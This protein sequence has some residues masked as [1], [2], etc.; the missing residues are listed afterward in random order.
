[1]KNKGFTLPEILVSTVIAILVA[2]CL[3]NLFIVGR[4]S[5]LIGETYLDL[6]QQARMAMDAVAKELSQS[7]SSQVHIMSCP[8]LGLNCSGNIVSFKLPISDT[9]DIA[10]TVFKPDGTIKWGDMG[11][12]GREILF[13]AT[14]SPSN[15]LIRRSVFSS[16]E[17]AEN[18]VAYDIIQI[19]FTGFT[20]EGQPTA[21]NPAMVKI[22]V[23]AQRAAL[24]AGN[25]SL[26][27]T[28][29]VTFR[30]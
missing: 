7:G 22:S 29:S 24:I 13:Y 9:L 2:I 10:N 16:S 23:L 30:N 18:N 4:N 12:E 17:T 6:Q 1:M 20:A 3:L 15:K 14:G 25:L 21:A 8:Y 5:W 11:R 26:A 28:S 27:L 19:N